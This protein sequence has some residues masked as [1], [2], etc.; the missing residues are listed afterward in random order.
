MSDQRTPTDGRQGQ[1]GRGKGGSEGRGTQGGEG[2]R[3]KG[4]RGDGVVRV[5]AEEY[6]CMSLHQ[7][8]AMEQDAGVPLGQHSGP[9]A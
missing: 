7:R 3:G 6:A 1:T 8:E 5:L 2:G 4:G 9:S